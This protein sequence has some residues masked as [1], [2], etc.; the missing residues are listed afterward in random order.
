MFCKKPPKKV[1]KTQPD[2][3]NLYKAK[4]ELFMQ[5]IDVTSK[6]EKDNQPE[7]KMRGEK[8]LIKILNDRMKNLTKSG[9]PYN[10]T[11]E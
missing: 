1:K 10:A 6:K 9:K 4:Q 2:V 7:F 8:E 3:F 11:Y 5:D